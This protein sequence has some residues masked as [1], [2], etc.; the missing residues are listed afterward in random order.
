M[1]DEK[2][3]QMLLD[4]LSKIRQ[5]LEILTRNTLKE[6]LEKIATMDERKRIWAIKKLRKVALITT[7]KRDYPKRRFDFIPSD[8]DFEMR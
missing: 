2:S 7:E 6:E 5:L 3:I 1:T 4:E 8:W